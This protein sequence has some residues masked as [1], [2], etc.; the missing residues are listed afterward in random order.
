MAE[1]R[2]S[3]SGA[4]TGERISDWLSAVR[5]LSNSRHAHLALIEEV[6]QRGQEFVVMGPDLQATPLV[7]H[8][9]QAP[10]N[11]RQL[12][13]W[14]V[15]LSSVGCHLVEQAFPLASGFPRL[16]YLAVREG[17]MLV[18]DPG[19]RELLE[20]DDGGGMEGALWRFGSLFRQL[21]APGELP[22]NLEWIVARCE[23]PRGLGY[24]DFAELSQALKDALVVEV[25]E[26]AR[27]VSKTALP[28]LSHFQVPWLAT[29]RKVPFERLFLAL[30]L[31]VA[32]VWG[33]FTWW[34]QPPPPRDYPA[35]VLG[36][37]DEL[38]LLDLDSGMIRQRLK[39]PAPVD[40]TRLAGDWLL[41]QCQG[42]AR[43]QAF[44]ARSLE[45]RVGP[46]IDPDPDAL[47]VDDTGRWLYSLSARRARLLLVQLPNR[48]LAYLDVLPGSRLMLSLPGRN[49]LVASPDPARLRRYS[50]TTM[51][52]E[53]ERELSGVEALA[54]DDEGRCW[55]ARGNRLERLDAELRTVESVALHS[56]PFRLLAVGSRLVCIQPGGV[57]IWDKGALSRVALDSQ[58]WDVQ[59]D[60]RY[61]DRIWI[62]QG[63]AL[64]CLDLGTGRR[65][66]QLPAPPSAR[67][68]TLLPGI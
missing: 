44:H 68:L 66:R 58:P 18:R 30:A 9:R 45:A 62:L 64:I 14:A 27:L 52:L 1:W 53:R 34:G 2:F 32:L 56:P 49:L 31:V 60:P 21:V 19:L 51:L 8:C 55:I 13:K 35:A 16:E 50:L 28:V 10:P 12:L 61:S 24:Q 29:V 6:T 65:L 23:A 63:Q 17:Q 59:P 33:M 26:P 54:Q 41:V 7:E 48:P 25:P 67:N 43:L 38:R 46:A 57:E 39:L 3:P 11:S 40:T 37:G 42:L 20:P 36:C 4:L 5:R 15:Q 22:A 47:T